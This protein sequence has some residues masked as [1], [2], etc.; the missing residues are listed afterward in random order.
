MVA[1]M[2]QSRRDDLQVRRVVLM[3]CDVL[4]ARP[5]FMTSLHFFSLS[6]YIHQ[7]QEALKEMPN[8]STKWRS[9]ST[10]AYTVSS[11]KNDRVGSPNVICVSG[12]SP[13]A[14]LLPQ[15]F[16][17]MVRIRCQN[18]GANRMFS[19][20]FFVSQSSQEKGRLVC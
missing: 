19:H 8:Q 6:S 1:G 2:E 17:A 11:C 15:G 3:C 9:L 18:S 20:D 14:L 10:L 13:Y 16:T 7:M 12:S 5:M 4:G